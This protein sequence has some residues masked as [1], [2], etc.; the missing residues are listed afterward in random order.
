VKISP[1]FL[2]GLRVLLVDDE[3][4]M[5]ELLTTVLEE[6]GAEV[7]AVGSVDE[8]IET[9][10]HLKPDVLVS[11]IGMPEKNGYVLIRQVRE[12]EAKF[13]T[14]VPAIALTAYAREEDHREALLAGFQLH[15]AKPVK[16]AELLT[17]VA[18]AQRPGP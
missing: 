4:D 11:D 17:A 12:R 8:A 14:K 9:L 18:I 16:A 6:H 13:G 7:T 1:S 3:A 10:E 5:R 15:I 2:N